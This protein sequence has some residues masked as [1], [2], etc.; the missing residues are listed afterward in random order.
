MTEAG[1]S[2]VREIEEQD[3]PA[4]WQMMEPVIRQG[5]TY[6]YARDMTTGGAHHMWLDVTEAAYVAV[7]ESGEILGSYYIKPNQPTLGAHVANCGYMVAE[8]ARGRGVATQMCKHSQEEAVRL[9]YRAMQFNLVV[10]SNEASVHLWKKMG[11]DIV[12]TLTGAFDHPDH[13]Y[14]DAYVMYKTLVDE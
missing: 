14:V 4:V 7:G 1:L 9:G 5:Q 10:K 2:Q 12:G 8:R 3:W 11:F 6:P 13:G